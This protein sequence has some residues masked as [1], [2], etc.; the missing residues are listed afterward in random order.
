MKSGL[1]AYLYLMGMNS[2]LEKPAEFQFTAIFS[3]YPTTDFQSLTIVSTH[4]VGESLK[5]PG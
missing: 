3:P 1:P 4:T 2:S 5:T